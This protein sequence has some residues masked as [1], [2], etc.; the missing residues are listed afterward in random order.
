MYSAGASDV[1]DI[2]TGTSS[3]LA[4]TI[5]L[6]RTLKN[7]VVQMKEQNLP[8]EQTDLG[9]MGVSI[10]QAL[11]VAPSA[12]KA[13]GKELVTHPI[14]AMQEHPVFTMLDYLTLLQGAGMATRG[15][16]RLGQEAARLAEK[17]L[18]TH[19]QVE[20]ILPK[21]LEPIPLGEF[22]KMAPG[23]PQADVSAAYAKHVQDVNSMNASRLQ[24]F[25]TVPEPPPPPPTSQRIANFLSPTGPDVPMGK[26]T[27]QAEYSKNPIIKVAQ[28]GLIKAADASP[29]VREILSQPGLR[30]WAPTEAI[31]ETARMALESPKMIRRAQTAS[32][33]ERDRNIR[34]IKRR[35]GA[36]APDEQKSFMAVV[37]GRASM[38]KPSPQFEDAYKFWKEKVLSEQ[39]KWS[40]AEEQAKRVAYQPL[41][42]AMH[43]KDEKALQAVREVYTRA[44]TGD[45]AAR[46][47][48]TKLQNAIDE[49]RKNHVLEMVKQ[50]ADGKASKVEI[51]EAAKQMADELAPTPL[52]FPHVFAQKIKLSDFL[53]ST[54]LQKFKPGFLKVRT[55]AEGYIA[56]DPVAVLAYHEA[57]V[58][59]FNA[60]KKIIDSV[61]DFAEPLAKAKD[62]K[63]G[64]KVFAPDGYLAFYRAKMGFD[65]KFAGALA[66]GL[67][68]DEAF[69]EGIISEVLPDQR[70][71]MAVGRPKL[72]QIPAE[73]AAK[74]QEAIKP[75]QV[76][77]TSL[78]PIVKLVWDKPLN[79]FRFAVL[80]M[81][82]AWIINNM[83]GNTV[84]SLLS[85]V[86]LPG[87]FERLAKK[88]WRKTIAPA[89]DELAAGGFRRSEERF[90]G[91]ARLQ[92]DSIVERAA[93]TVGGLITGDVTIDN[94]LAD[95]TRK[96]IT[97]PIRGVRGVAHGMFEIN[98][99]LED[100]YR[101]AVFIDR[102]A[103]EASRAMVRKNSSLMVQ[104]IDEVN[105]FFGRGKFNDKNLR[106][107]VEQ[108]V[109]DP[110]MRGKL[111]DQTN[112]ILND[113]SAMSSFERGVIRRISPF[114]SWWKFMNVF[115]IKLAAKNPAMANTARALAMMGNDIEDR[116][117]KKHGLS[118][119]ALPD[120][121]RGAAP[122]GKTAEGN[123]RA[124]RAQ[125]MNPLSTIGVES[126]G[127]S[128]QV[129]MALE[130]KTGKKMFTG[131]PFT[132]PNV[133]ELRN[134][135]FVEYDPKTKQIRPIPTGPRPP[136]G[137][138][139]LR[140]FIPP[141]ADAEKFIYPYRFY[142][143]STLGE[144]IPMPDRRGKPMKIDPM[145][146]LSAI[147]G[148]PMED[149]DPKLLKLSEQE[150]KRAGPTIR[151]QLKRIEKA[152]DAIRR[153]EAR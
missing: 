147:L 55:G 85:G 125:G 69:L 101:N 49:S 53:P 145:L 83:V 56:N 39:E 100:A 137:A 91:Q 107:K 54:W 60:Q 37:E 48:V 92:S 78:R 113:Y 138:Y 74:V 124:M 38:V 4:Q 86:N 130:Y 88:S 103:K 148:L 77:P 52:Y 97:L 102:A 129:N 9:R 5:M 143:T 117:W 112:E 127:F 73:V 62:L 61:M 47:Q 131:K 128:P 43:G 28:L 139:L 80:G 119:R 84:T 72:Y 76:I 35:V 22:E 25:T 67:N 136:L 18:M 104:A 32:I 24:P 2:V 21:V 133:I 132:S 89:A 96:L 34:E 121:R 19:S 68:I 45:A 44:H 153:E 142:D 33:A 41:V 31:N 98:A 51:A 118:P 46:G 26:A 20:R 116:E 95:A 141:A 114:W 57:Q 105:A 14:K 7:S 15:G 6:P 93:Q 94:R 13:R 115:A 58:Q 134:G 135:E 71:V 99:K 109:N 122:L 65:N 82:P 29:A 126:F 120:Y 16:L 123:I 3:L 63:P 66:K 10:G 1:K 50:F 23:V 140:N 150:I 149:I 87:S 17:P 144:R 108:M 81:R 11:A 152:K 40:I 90:M 64:Y 12:I 8:W 75:M 30:V 79:A 59:K 106:L 110:G 151:R 36:M 111:I 27:V 70:S 146:R 42:L